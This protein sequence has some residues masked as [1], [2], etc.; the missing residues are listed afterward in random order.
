[1]WVEKPLEM[2]FFFNSLC[3][4]VGSIAQLVEHRTFNPQVP[5]SSLGG[6]TTTNI[7]IDMG[8]RYAYTTTVFCTHEET[9]VRQ[10][11]T[12]DDENGAYL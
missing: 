9:W 1:V 12:S 3:I 7:N 6:P 2:L 11:E 4:G 5:S 10:V 8:Y